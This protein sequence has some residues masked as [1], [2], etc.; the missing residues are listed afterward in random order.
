[1]LSSTVR[2]GSTIA[3]GDYAVTVTEPRIH[4]D[5]TGAIMMIVDR[6]GSVAG[7]CFDMRAGDWVRITSDIR[8]KILRV[9]SPSTPHWKVTVGIEAPKEIPIVR[10]SKQKT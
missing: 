5:F 7:S 6:P 3:V 8:V 2:I 10:P 9:I 1:M 4:S